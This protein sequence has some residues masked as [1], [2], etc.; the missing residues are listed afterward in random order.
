VVHGTDYLLVDNNVA[1]DTFGHCFMVEDGFERFNTFSNN[2]GARTK[3]ATQIIPNLP[4]KG[5]GDETDGSAATYWITNPMNYFEN[6]VAAG[7]QFSGYWF[8]LRSRPRGSLRDQHQGA[9]WNLRAMSLGSF[10][11][12]VAHSYDSA[13]I[14]TYPNGYVPDNVAIF[15][16][17]RSYRNDNDGMFIH[18]SRN[19]TLKGFHFADNEHGL[20]LDRIDLFEMHDSVIVG[21][22]KDYKDKV[23][24][25]SAPNVCAGN[26]TYVRGVEMH[27]FRHGRGILEEGFGSKVQ[28]A[29]KNTHFSGFDDTGCETSAVF[30]ADNEVRV[31]TWDY[32]TYLENSKVDD[33]SKGHIA[34]FCRAVNVGITDSYIIDKNSAFGGTTGTSTIMSYTTTHNKL[35]AFVEPTL[36]HDHPENCFSYCEN[37]C[38]RTVTF[39]VDPGVSEGYKLKV[40][41]KNDSQNRCETF[42]NRYNHDSV[43]RFRIFSPALPAGTYTAEFLDELDQVSWPRG[44]NVTYEVDMCDGGAVLDDGVEMVIPQLDASLCENLI[45]NGDAEWSDTDPGSWVYEKNTGIE[46]VQSVG[47]SGSNAFGDVRVEIHDGGLTQHLDTRCLSLH[48]GRQYEVEAYVKLIDRN[49]QPVYC[50]PSIKHSWGCPRIILNYGV[51]RRNQE[52]FLRDR[53]I[54]AG[55][56]RARN[57]NTDGYQL[58]NGIVTIGDDLADASNVRFFVERRSNN[59]EM[60]VDNVS[61][62]LISQSTCDVGEELV[63][64][65][66]FDGGTSEF[67]DDYNA[68]GFQIVSPGVG[69][70]GFALKT[71]TGSAQHS[72]KSNCIEA[73][74][75]YVAQAKYRLLD[76]SGNPVTCN[77]RTGNPRCPEMSL[78]SYDENDGYLEYKGQIASALDETTS[79]SDGYSTLWGIFEPSE[80]TGSAADV[81]IFFSHTGQGMI[82]DSVSVQEMSSGLTTLGT[83]GGSSPS[84]CG[85]LIVNGDN[86][87][88]VAN[89][90]SGHGVGND[91]IL[92]TAGF[93]GNG[94]AARVTG[95]SSSWRGMWYSGERYVDSVN[96]LTASSKWKISAQIRLLNPGTDIGADCDTSE[97]V[98]TQKRCPRIRVKFYDAGDRYTPVREEIVYNYV[99]N[100]NSNGWNTFEAQV[101]LPSIKHNDFNKISILVADVRENIDIVVDNLTMVPAS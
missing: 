63:S 29:F 82:L 93:G 47:I 27:T 90:W 37:T 36:C 74:K 5:N 8:E 71:T 101:E 70:S 68:E 95:R 28:G 58:V 52:R 2:L 13:G 14:R 69:G 38:L 87:L 41:K 23:I 78:K 4:S 62:T 34:N 92:T 72:I 91:K 3:R 12:N 33:V 54:E 61:M 40:C 77:A 1:Y 20:D 24:S 65:G 100:W 53:E 42:Q 25:Q 83:S 57:V 46:I 35:Q 7:G 66:D 67:W 98:D 55:I 26:P 64:N 96:C 79:T 51:Y 21:R 89:F 19:I 10:S 44:L 48:K 59:M 81:R 99:G 39:R 94:E 84:T 6:N 31:G 49:G 43:D 80:L 75:R 30:W 97:R 86:E 76:R 73:G 15:E 60:F 32:W 17:S 85:D 22:S 11:G 88:G 9:E 56:T 50:D 16:N 18:N 45:S